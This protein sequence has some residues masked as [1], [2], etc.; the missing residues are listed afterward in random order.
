MSPRTCLGTHCSNTLGLSSWFVFT[1]VV[2]HAAAAQEQPSDLRR[3]Q[4]AAFPNPWVPGCCCVRKRCVPWQAN[5]QGA[6]REAVMFSRALYRESTESGQGGKAITTKKQNRTSSFCGVLLR[7]VPADAASCHLTRWDDR[8]GALWGR[9]RN[10]I[11]S[12]R[13][14]MFWQ[15][16][17]P[18]FDSCFWGRGPKTGSVRPQNWVRGPNSG[19]KKWTPLLRSSQKRWGEFSGTSW[20]QNLGTGMGATEVRF[21]I[22]LACQIPFDLQCTPNTVLLLAM[23]P[24]RVSLARAPRSERFL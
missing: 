13:E 17:V 6:R 21:P 11:G 19:A 3:G 24:A 14:A 16:R 4:L 1:G 9:F 7:A 12:S 22:S 18:H 23:S 5:S 15:K 20:C 10:R 2:A 8:P